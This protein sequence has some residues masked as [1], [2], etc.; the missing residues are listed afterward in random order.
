MNPTGLI[1]I[2]RATYAGASGATAAATY[3]F[4]T[5]GYGPPAQD[6]HIDFDIVHNQNG[7]FKWIYDNGPGFKRWP[8][9]VIT[10]QDVFQYLVGANAA[11]QFDRLLELWEHKGNLV[12]EGPDGVHNIHWSSDPQEQSFIR[13]PR[14]EGDKIEMDVQ[15]QFEEA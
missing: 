13:Y 7:K 2:S 14:Q 9:F 15:V 10:C 11:A 4:M 5:K 6:R 3:Q 8:A 1:T 12:I